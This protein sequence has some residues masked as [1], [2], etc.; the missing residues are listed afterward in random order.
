VIPGT[1]Y[2]RTIDGFDIAFQV[3]GDGPLDI[4][5][6][7][8]W[9]SH[10]EVA[11]ENS[12][13]ARF[14]QRVAAFA[15]VISYDKRG[16]GLSSRLTDAPDLETRL[17]D[18]RAVLDAVGAQ[19]IAI[20]GDGSDG[21][22]LGMLHAATFPARTSALVLW[23]P[24][25]RNAWANDHPWGPTR[26]EFELEQEAIRT[27][28][29]TK[30]WAKAFA[31]VDAP[32]LARYPELLDGYAK[33]F[34]YSATPSDA[35]LLNEIWFDTDVRDLL[36]TVRVP[37]LVLTRGLDASA[38]GSP[39]SYV[40]ERIPGATI[41]RVEGGDFPKW[42]GDQAVVVDEVRSFLTGVRLG[43]EPDRVLATVVFTDIVGSSEIVAGRGD[44][45]WR[46]LVERHHTVVRGVLETF[47]GVEVDTAGDG[48]FAT[49]DGPTRGVRCAQ[50][51]REAVGGLGLEVRAGVHTGEVD[52]GGGKA[53][54]IA[55]VIGSRIAAAASTGEILVSSTVKDLV[56][57]SGL[58][59]DGRGRHELKGVPGSW[60]LFALSER[61][62]AS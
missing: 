11:W 49:F 39:A 8:A 14:M 41:V 47:R 34:R 51:I 35:L 26:E 58:S 28:W 7:P 60:E 3:L 50:A 42:L 17:D 1:Q 52:I 24:S 55:V 16:T 27:S 37:T 59:F 29:G 19:R 4:L 48:F 43:P 56:A 6:I 46:E 25:A 53:T 38:E 10:L 22:A 31:G 54:G 20:W 61:T 13:Y 33:Y 45:G 40:A 12:L 2:A 30:E 57:G 62:G 5:M 44:A 18:A 15:R 32:T 23:E 21:A 9:V 36:P